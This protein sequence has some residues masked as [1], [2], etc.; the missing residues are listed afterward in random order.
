[1]KYMIISARDYLSHEELEKRYYNILKKYNLTKE[2]IDDGYEAL[3]EYSIEIN[4]IEELEDL[5]KDLGEDIIMRDKFIKSGSIP[6]IMI[7]D[8]YIE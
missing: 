2:K 8:D 5:R 3:E 4:N 1:M 7:Y 6:Q